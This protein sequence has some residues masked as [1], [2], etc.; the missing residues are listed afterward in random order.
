MASDKKKSKPKEG[1]YRFGSGLLWAGGQFAVNWFITYEMSMWTTI[2]AIAGA[3]IAGWSTAAL[4][5]RIAKW[6]AGTNLMMV[7]GVLLG[8]AIF[9]GA[10]S[11]LAAVK[12]WLSTRHLA[13]DWEKLQESL[14]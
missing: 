8:V 2:T 3:F 1:W 9:T 4:L 13:V 10:F 14:L 12:D 11:G 7:A 5:G 6:G